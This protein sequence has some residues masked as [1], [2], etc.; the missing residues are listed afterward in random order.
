MNG[1]RLTG[2]RAYQDALANLLDG[3][4]RNLSPREFVAVRFPDTKGGASS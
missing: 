3:A 4:E 2:L 1:A